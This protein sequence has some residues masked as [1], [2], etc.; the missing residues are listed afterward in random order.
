MSIKRTLLVA[1][2]ASLA[3]VGCS[4]N[5][6]KRRVSTVNVQVTA[7]QQDISKALIRSSEILATG[8]PNESNEG[9]LNY[10]SFY[11]Q[12][13][14]T[15]IDS[16]LPGKLQLFEL[17]TLPANADINQA[18]SKSRCQWVEGCG[19]KE[20]GAD[21]SPVYQWQSV[22][23]DLRKDERVV[24][25]PL[26][27]LAAALAFEYA[28]AETP[29]PEPVQPGE[30]PVPIDPLWQK[31]GYYSPY[32][33]EQAIS[34]VSKL[35][36]LR[37]VQNSFPADLTRINSLNIN[38][39]PESAKNSIRYGAILAAWAH[40]QES[41][42]GFTND[43]TQ[44]FLDNKAQIVQK[45]SEDAVVQSTLTLE[46]VYT[47]AKNNLEN[48][49]INNAGIKTLVDNVII[50]LNTSLSTLVDVDKEL[51]DVR[52]ETIKELF[53]DNAFND[54][55]LGVGRTKLFVKNLIDTT[56]KLIDSEYFF[57][58]EYDKELKSYIDQQK[59]FFENNKANLNGVVS[60]LNDAQKIYIDSYLTSSCANVDAYP[61]IKE[62][63]YK[64][65]VLILTD[66][67]DHAI[68]LE[69]KNFEGNVQA[70]DIEMKGELLIDKLIF[71]LKDTATNKSRVRLFYAQPTNVIPT[72]TNPV[73]GYEYQ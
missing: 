2:T 73:I 57:G 60:Q 71:K 23:W 51:T 19:S 11:T 44:E 35:F 22:V 15:A 47:A 49:P 45:D 37:N 12:D 50:D 5:D 62:C 42:P 16:V 24:V 40:L 70:I 14:G 63:N 28:Y 43:A 46:V 3:L 10:Q 36:G 21:I 48:L 38:N 8:M 52:P 34:Q 9:T 66:R 64:N 27:H 4:D 69:M 41:T 33:V 39:D 20:F 58:E 31:T 18:A 6:D 68:T 1:L 53:G 32:S 30:T 55:E 7:G 56:T 67:S 72:A 13:N 29:E 26:T 17:V 59:L 54:Y 25:T 61:W 65:K